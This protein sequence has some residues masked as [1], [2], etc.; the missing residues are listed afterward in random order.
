M[1]TDIH[2]RAEVRKDGR[3]TTVGPIFVNT[4]FDPSSD[5]FS[6]PHFRHSVEPFSD[7]N[8]N[9]FAILA[10]VR[11]GHGFAGVPTST[12]FVPICDQR[13]LPDDL[14]PDSHCDPS[15]EDGRFYFGDH[16]YSWVTLAELEAYDWHGQKTTKCGWIHGA[17]RCRMLE[18]GKDK[19][20][21][22]CGSVS[23]GR[24]EH[25]GIGELDRRVSEL[26]C[27]E[28]LACLRKKPIG[29]S[30][31]LPLDG[32][33]AEFHWDVTYADAVGK[34]WMDRVMPTL[35]GLGKAEDVRIVFGFDS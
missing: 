10:D 11:N 9:L 15:D 12:G 4:M 28:R 1:G 33:Y 3:W 20:E 27:E 25:V 35:R 19:P 23:G 2:M 5:Y 32:V 14:D 21:E 18:L 30:H 6:R 8:Y 29:G 24:I 31:Y 17:E 26:T 13:G 16:S 7:R 22:W 34:T